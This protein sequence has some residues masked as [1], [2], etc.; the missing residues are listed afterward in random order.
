MLS[1][2][3]AK[4][5]DNPYSWDLKPSELH[6]L[7][8]Y[9]II[10]LDHVRRIIVLFLRLS[11]ALSFVFLY[12][13]IAKTKGEMMQYKPMFM[14]CAV[15]DAMFYIG[16]TMVEYKAKAVDGVF[17][18]KFEGMMGLT[19]WHTQIVSMGLYIFLL[20][21]AISILPA[22]FYYR[23]C[24]LTSDKAMSKTRI[25][26]LFSISYSVGI[27]I[28]IL[29]YF[30]YGYSATIRPTFNYGRLWFPERPLPT[31][32]YADIRHPVVKLYFGAA[33]ALISIFY[34]V[35]LVIGHRT[36]KV[37]NSK[38]YGICKKSKNTQN[39]VTYFLVVQISK[40]SKPQMNKEPQCSPSANNPYA[41]EVNRTNPESL[42]YY[43]RLYL[44]S[45]RPVISCILHVFGLTSFLF[46]F[47]VLFQTKG[48]VTRYQPI[49]LLSAV[50][51]VCFYTLSL[52]TQIKSKAT[53]GVF[54]MKL[55][56]L[57]S[58]FDWE[59]QL[60]GIACFCMLLSLA[61]STLPSLFYFRYHALTSTRPM[62]Q[63]RLAVLFSSSYLLAI[64]IAAMA[65]VAYGYS[66]EA[67]PGFNYGV[68]WFP[69]TPLPTVF[70]GDIRH[71][72]LK[73]YYGIA[74]SLITMFYVMVLYIGL[75]TVKAF[76]AK[77]MTTDKKAR[78]TQRQV[79]YFLLIQSV[80]PLFVSS[81][82]N[83]FLI[84][85]SM[86]HLDGGI[87]LTL[88]FDLMMLLPICNAILS[89]IVIK[90]YRHAIV[91]A[92]KARNQ[93]VHASNTSPGSSDV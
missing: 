27:P 74:S 4:N 33:I 55:E 8:P 34:C 35:V 25:T 79:T 19:S 77:T 7:R 87:L 18:L 84:L 47:L 11:G 62:S 70:Y 82:P 58:R 39:Q 67:R 12:L 59:W 51:D 52:I 46:L 85:I 28:G 80:I 50:T 26:F 37:F 68:L 78:N 75:I 60:I 24:I 2:H 9:E 44:D 89:I 93:S 73:L 14:L 45:V 66:A 1:L 88:V 53:D 5:P 71:T 43:E 69:E 72:F 48:G 57:L 83:T 22:Q 30:A 49:F 32:I 10:Y 17:M 40:L 64:A 63:L 15:T 65:Y 91:S 16:N 6:Q 81:G 61:I 3:Y 20:S 23:Y 42:E 56:G 38:T 90:P 41:W 29:A 13:V 31:V 21:L 92:F 54:M 86:F 36:V 76:K